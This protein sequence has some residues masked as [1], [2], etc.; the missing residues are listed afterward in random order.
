MAFKTIRQTKD[1]EIVWMNEKSDTIVGVYK[2]V[3][4]GAGRKTFDVD[5]DRK[6]NVTTPLK[7][8]NRNQAITFARKWMKAHPNG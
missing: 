7:K 3:G 8:V 2:D 1:G 5:I 4:W 6:M